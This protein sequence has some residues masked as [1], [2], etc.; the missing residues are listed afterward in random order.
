LVS[1]FF[2]MGLVLRTVTESARI[3]QTLTDT[4]SRFGEPAASA[5]PNISMDFRESGDA[6]SLHIDRE[7]GCSKCRADGSF[8]AAIVNNAPLFRG[9]FV[10]F[11]FY[12]MLA[13]RGLMTVHAAALVRGG[14]A[15]LLRGPSGAGKT[16]LAYAA[17]C[18]GWQTLGDRAIS[19]DVSN[20]VWWGM[21]WWFHFPCEAARLV[22]EISGCPAFQAG[23]R[24]RVELDLEALWPGRAVYRAEPGAVIL[25]D[26]AAGCSS[27]IEPIS[28]NESFEHW[29]RGAAGTETEFPDY[30]LHVEKAL[31]LP[32]WRLE[33]G[34]DVSE[35]VKLLDRV[36]GF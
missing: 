13:T 15:V 22:P 14:K 6:P 24:E 32:A 34:D 9:Q 8:P 25:I 7:Q 26:R 31:A 11:A 23:S 2:P 20:S 4:F 5:E 12:S 1:Y 10:Q 27:R 3:Q 29:M 19:I 21:P 35:A 18:A 16:T 28:G 33:F 36:T 17:V 30:R